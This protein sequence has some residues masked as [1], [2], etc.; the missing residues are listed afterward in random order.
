MVDK[1]KEK[2]RFTT[3]T[4]MFRTRLFSSSSSSSSFIC[5]NLFYVRARVYTQYALVREIRT[6]I[7]SSTASIC[8]SFMYFADSSTNEANI[9]V[10]SR[11]V[12]YTVSF[13]RA[14]K[15]KSLSQRIWIF[16]PDAY[17]LVYLKHKWKVSISRVYARRLLV[18][19]NLSTH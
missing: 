14:I 9:C 7:K 1:K 2:S 15:R 4:T 11:L 12:P 6:S 18:L 16:A 13:L 10:C 19:P 8:F 3:R 5:E 17:R